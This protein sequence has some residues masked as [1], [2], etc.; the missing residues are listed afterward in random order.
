MQLVPPVILHP[1]RMTD[2]EFYDF[3]QLYPDFRV[4]RTAEGTV[5]IERGAGLETSARGCDICRQLGNWA[6][7]DGRGSA[8]LHSEFMLASGAAYTPCLSWTDNGSIARLTREQKRKFPPLCPVF[9][10]ELT[11]PVD[12]LSHMQKKMHEWIENG[13]QLGWLIDADKRTVY[14]YRP[15]R[16]PEI[17]EHLDRLKGEGPVAGFV[18]ELTRIWKSL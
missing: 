4:E 7:E 11:S 13:A 14:I 18:L 1:P 6:I 8:F 9:I 10:V 5:I 15:G 12:S 17:V 2:D 3:C 16:E